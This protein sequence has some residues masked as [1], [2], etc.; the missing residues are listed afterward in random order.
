MRQCQNASALGWGGR[1]Q[2]QWFRFALNFRI[3]VAL[4]LHHEWNNIIKVPALKSL[5]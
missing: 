1:L 4:L 2:L 3:Q 5:H